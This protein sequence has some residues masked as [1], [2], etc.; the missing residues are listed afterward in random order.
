MIKIAFL[1]PGQGAQK[2]G[3]GKEF[4]EASAEARKVFDTAESIIGN[5]FKNIIFEGPV[6]K[7]TST[8]FCQPAIITM[9]LAALAAFEAH[10]K[11]T[12]VSPRFAAGLS[13]GEY[14][15]LAS[16]KAF[17]L[18][19][20][21]QLIRKRA[22]LMEEATKISVGKMAAIIGLDRGML[23]EICQKTGAQIANIN[24]LE[25]VVITGH[26]EKVLA[27]CEMAKEKGAK[28]VIPLEVSG[29]FHSSLMKP[30]ADQFKNELVLV[31]IQET[32]FPVITNVSASPEQDPEEIRA[33][34][35][36]QITSSVQWVDSILYM[37][38]QG[39]KDFVEIGP[40]KVL[41]GLL[42]KINPELNVYNIEKPQDIDNLPF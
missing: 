11:F 25:Q 22:L 37:S 19:D 39:I 32:N 1:F 31:N 23:A 16:A 2:V 36:L 4:Y 38:S 13:L 9:S 28:S 27:A 41:K 20:A 5:N 33:N 3:M 6:E 24:S 18:S 29:A 40:G 17:L 34:L 42:R 10:P 14:S 12:N 35:A 30:A 15:A 26:A 8:A 7:L 21:I